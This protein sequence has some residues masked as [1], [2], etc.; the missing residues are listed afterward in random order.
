MKSRIAENE[1]DF[2]QKVKALVDK[3]ERVVLSTMNGESV[4][5]SFD[6]TNK[7]FEF[8]RMKMARSLP[9]LIPMSQKE[10]QDIVDD[11]SKDAIS[12]YILAGGKP[13]W[14]LMHSCN[15]RYWK[16]SAFENLPKPTYLSDGDTKA[17]VKCGEFIARSYP[18]HKTSL[19]W[20]IYFW[21]NKIIGCVKSPIT[22]II[23]CGEEIS[24]NN[25]H[26]FHEDDNVKVRRKIEKL[27]QY[28]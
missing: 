20:E 25:L 14:F 28:S 18:L 2:W 24:E 21:K 27:K 22:G 11:A 5:Y 19:W 6:A 7:R 9:Y 4:Q 10:I 8:A 13:R 26:L 23:G 12:V 16:Q 15:C 1:D 17:A 3:G